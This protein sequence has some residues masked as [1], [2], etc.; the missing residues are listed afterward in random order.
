[1]KC[2][3]HVS[4]FVVHIMHYNASLFVCQGIIPHSC[5]SATSTRNS[6][7]KLYLPNVCTSLCKSIIVYQSIAIW[8]AL[9]VELKKLSS[10]KSL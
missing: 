7:Y 8:N 4:F 1:M 10:F 9:P 5:L 3:Y 6:Q 2:H